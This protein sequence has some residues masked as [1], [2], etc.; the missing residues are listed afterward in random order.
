MNKEG[1]SHIEV[2]LAFVLFVGFIMFALYFFNPLNSSRLVDT[3][4][5]YLL[6]EIREKTEVAVDFYSLKIDSSVSDESIQLDYPD[7]VDTSKNVASEGEDGEI[8]DSRVAGNNIFVDR[9]NNDFIKLK[10]SETITEN[11]NCCQNAKNLEAQG[12]EGKK[13]ILA[14]SNKRNI[15]SEKKISEINKTYYEN[16]NA[17]KEEFNLPGRVNFA[18]VFFLSNKEVRM[19]KEIPNNFEVFTE[20][21]R[22]ELI[23]D[24]NGKIEF[25]DLIIKVW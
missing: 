18:I 5:D 14:S 9:K 24:D 3:S 17:L 7:D 2:I 22:V 10:F 6:N 19:E 23:R 1:A 13:Y 25:A 15:I 21:T 4:V 20:E 16:Y 12:N 11:D 8:L